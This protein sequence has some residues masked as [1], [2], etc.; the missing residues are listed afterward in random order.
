MFAYM[1]LCGTRP[2]ETRI[3]EVADQA[4]AKAGPRAAISGTPAFA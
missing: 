3:E 4:R 2:G 1:A